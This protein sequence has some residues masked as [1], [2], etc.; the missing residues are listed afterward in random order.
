MFN[1]LRGIEDLGPA[2][3]GARKRQGISMQ[4]WARV[5]GL[6][7]QTLHKLESGGDVVFSTVIAAARA[8]GV[9]I[10]LAPWTTPTLDEMRERFRHLDDDVDDDV[11]I[12]APEDDA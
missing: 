3:R 2:L 11:D 10:E 4:E 1:L 5:S 9:A 6:S 12:D 8:I 7:R